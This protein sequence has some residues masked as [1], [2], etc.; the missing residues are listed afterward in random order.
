MPNI[1]GIIF[2]FLITA[3]FVYIIFHV[4]MIRKFVVGS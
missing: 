4:A 3:I 2:S 1:M